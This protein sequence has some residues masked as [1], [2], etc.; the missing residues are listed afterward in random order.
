MAFRFRRKESAIGGFH[1]V[2][3]EQTAAGVSLLA[4]RGN[5]LGDRV[6]EARR[7][8]KRIRAILQLVGTGLP[9]EVL[10]KHDEALASV[11]R[12]LAG[13]RDADVCLSTFE[14][15]TK[16]QP[17]AEATEIH[18]HFREFARIARRAVTAAK[19]GKIAS[20]LRS[21]GAAIARTE[22]DRDGWALVADGFD[23]SYREARKL[24]RYATKK[25]SD[26]EL[27][28]WRKA[29]KRLF[30]QLELTRAF[31]PKRQRKTVKKLEQ[32]AMVLGEHH[33]LHVLGEHLR[34]YDD[35]GQKCAADVECIRALID[36]RRKDLCKCIRKI[37]DDGFCERPKAFLRAIHK[38]WKSD[39]I[40]CE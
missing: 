16:N 13:T 12:R 1:R 26:R 28:E 19:L 38:A 36:R 18:E 24:R 7:H 25:S 14:A 8:I 39:G 22:F 35:V 30:H 4:D 2:I 27:H 20:S 31:L 34:N 37:A 32:L 23:G 6:H 17:F 10:E 11:N 5:D 29:L 40:G 15:L 9:G 33:D 21:V 3:R